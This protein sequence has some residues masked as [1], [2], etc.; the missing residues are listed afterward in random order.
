MFFIKTESSDFLL[1]GGLSKFIPDRFPGSEV[2]PGFG[3]G[4]AF[5]LSGCFLAH[6]GE[7]NT[8]GAEIT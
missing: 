2:D 1:E 4:L 5:D 6:T 8:K 3:D 7:A